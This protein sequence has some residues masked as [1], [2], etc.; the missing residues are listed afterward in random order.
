MIEYLTLA[1]MS[2][3]PIS[4]ARGAIIYG[5]GLGMNTGLVLISAILLNI[6]AIPIIWYFLNVSN[7]NKLAYRLFGKKMEQKIDKYRNKFEKYAEWALLIFVA[8]PLPVTGAWTG[9]FIAHILKL[10]FKKS[11]YVISL[12]VVIAALIVFFITTGT[13]SLYNGG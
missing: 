12:G 5:L 8:V 11:F 13:I 7:F 9:T 4:E 6:L 1:L 3:A 2:M 10:D